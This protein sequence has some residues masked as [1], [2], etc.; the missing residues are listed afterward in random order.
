ME[1]ASSLMKNLS[2]MQG[3]TLL[4]SQREVLESL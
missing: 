4:T 2:L 3:F 1:S